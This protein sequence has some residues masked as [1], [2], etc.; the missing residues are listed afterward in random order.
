MR[1]KLGI[2][3]I[4]ISGNF[5]SLRVLVRGIKL[6]GSAVAETKSEQSDLER[7]APIALRNHDA[8]GR[9]N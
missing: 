1:L 9:N 8:V 7:S 4:P 6:T 2:A 5:P 3:E